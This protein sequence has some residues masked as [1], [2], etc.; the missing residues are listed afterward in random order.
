MYDV[1][2]SYR[3]KMGQLTMHMH[4]T[5]TVATHEEAK[6]LRLAI[7]ALMEK[8]GYDCTV[9]IKNATPLHTVDEAMEDFKRMITKYRPVKAWKA[10]DEQ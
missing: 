10:G 4:T 8:C 5:E 2:L 9:M 1:E 6:E 7:K 3:T